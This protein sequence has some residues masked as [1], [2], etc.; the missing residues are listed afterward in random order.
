MCRS[1]M[2]A[3][4]PRPSTVP[5]AM[6]RW[7]GR[8]RAGLAV[9]AILAA[10]TAGA[11]AMDRDGDQ[12]WIVAS[13]GAGIELARVA[14]APSREFALRYRNSVYESSAE[15]HFRVEDDH[16]DLV[17]LAADERAVLEEYYTAF[18]SAGD[19]RRSNLAWS[20]AVQRPPIEL[21]LRVQATALGERTLVTADGEL[22]LWRLVT[23][24]DDTVVI[25]TIEGSG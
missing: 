7:R 20:V 2:S 24:S 15:E 21:P 14:L 4:G 22:S 13:D 10:A 6:D 16:L 17:L 11:V 25:L 3:R 1:W 12:R 8:R 23:G 5:D 19:D 18:G 9:V